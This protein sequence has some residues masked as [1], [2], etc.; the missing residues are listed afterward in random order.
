MHIH[1]LFLGVGI[2]LRDVILAGIAGFCEVCR[3]I[4]SSQVGTSGGVAHHQGDALELS[5]KV[6][7][8]RRVIQE[9]V[10]KH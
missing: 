9:V 3:R 1:R 8:G 2:P 6:A 7:L 5:A 4:P 10:V